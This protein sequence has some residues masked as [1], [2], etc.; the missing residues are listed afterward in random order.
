MTLSECR[1]SLIDFD[2]SERDVFEVFG[3]SER[4]VR[5]RV[6]ELPL[7][8]S[9]FVSHMHFGRFFINTLSSASVFDL[10][11]W[12]EEVDVADLDLWRSLTCSSE[13]RACS[14][15]LPDD[16]ARSGVCVCILG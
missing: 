13:G 8:L 10:S 4:L 16:D 14:F 7:F 5:G 3:D 11:R 6:E 9:P 12:L 15:H 2:D 1:C